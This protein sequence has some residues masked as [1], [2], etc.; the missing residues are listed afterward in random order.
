MVGFDRLLED[1][2]HG[3]AEVV[4]ELANDDSDPHGSTENPSGNQ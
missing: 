2:P 1:A 4:R 3:G